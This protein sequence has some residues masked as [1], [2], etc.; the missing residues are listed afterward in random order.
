M[1]VRAAQEDPTWAY[2][3]H[4]QEA[5]QTERR[6]HPGTQLVRPL[7]QETS[8]R[9]PSLHT[10]A[11]L[12]M[13]RLGLVLGCLCGVWGA[14][15]TDMQADRCYGGFWVVSLIH[16]RKDQLDDPALLW[17]S[18]GVMNSTCGI[19]HSPMLMLANMKAQM[20][21][22]T[23]RSY[24]FNALRCL[25]AVMCAF[26]D[27]TSIQDPTAYHAWFKPQNLHTICVHDITH[28]LQAAVAACAPSFPPCFP[29]TQTQALCLRETHHKSHA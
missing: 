28:H 20:Q 13:L 27:H 29:S 11:Y 18:Q 16:R 12:G 5:A 9:G 25:R 21:L 14:G 8:Q 15:L 4:K 17:L 6:G 24:G 23:D 2:E 10:P 3:G 26:P 19:P 22:Y 7:G 1:D